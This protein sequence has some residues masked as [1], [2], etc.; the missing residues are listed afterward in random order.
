M[1]R[2]VV[3]TL[4]VLAM[5]VCVVASASGVGV[6]TVNATTG[7]KLELDIPDTTWDLTATGGGP[8]PPGDIVTMNYDVKVRSNKGYTIARAIDPGTLPGL[9]DGT[10]LVGDAA[11]PGAKARSV[12]NTW[13]SNLDTL[14]FTMG[15]ANEGATGTGSVTYTVTQP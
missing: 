10:T 5:F 4:V 11:L 6:V 2:T 8:V 9:A 13:A 3:I 15:W 12:S 7:A 14:T 1:K